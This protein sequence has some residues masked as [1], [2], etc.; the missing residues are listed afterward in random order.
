[1]EAVAT[2]ALWQ[3]A[4][5]GEALHAQ[6][7][8]E[9]EREALKLLEAV[10]K[11]CCSIVRID[12]HG[13]HRSIESLTHIY[14]PL[15]PTKFNKNKIK[16]KKKQEPKYCEGLS[17]RVATQCVSRL[18]HALEDEDEDETEA[19]AA[20]GEGG[21]GAMGF[22]TPESVAR[23]QCLANLLA[24]YRCGVLCLFSPFIFLFI[25]TFF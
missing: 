18:I 9:Q 12:I 20:A 1:M 3:M 7:R 4:E 19:A 24:N 25:F 6:Q 21:G 11:V 10:L 16:N 2:H 15:D 17:R 14:V 8:R 5:A 23:A 13:L 22:W